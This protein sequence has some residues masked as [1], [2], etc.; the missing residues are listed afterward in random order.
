MKRLGLLHTVLFL[1]DM[2]K[3]NLAERFPDLQS[4]HVVDESLLQDLLRHKGLTP[5]IVR[6][7]ASLACHVRDAGADLILFTCTSTSPAV[8][9]ARA[10]VDIPILKIDDPLAQ[11]AIEL[12]RKIGVVCTATSTLG[13]SEN[14]IREHAAKL[15]KQID[16][17]IELDS[18][19]FEAIMA[20]D[21]AEHDR[22][23]KAVASELSRDSDVVVL[24]QASMAH[25]AA[26]L[27]ETLPIPV[28][29]SPELCINALGELL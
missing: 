17:H 13:P 14:L 26:E 8:D 5:N 9:T 20:G 24:A 23:V 21:R 25:L 1:A 6:R 16:V 22:R 11:K 12:G 18:D 29:S 3:K 10:M 19:A 28:L 15:G 27:N 7:V 2:F 4:F